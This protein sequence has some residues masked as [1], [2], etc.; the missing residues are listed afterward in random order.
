[1]AARILVV[2]DTQE[3]LDTFRELLE[4]EA[5]EVILYSYAIMD[6]REIE[7]VNPDLI[8]LDYIFGGEQSGW[9]MLQ[10]L[11]MRRSTETIPVIICTAATAQ[12]REIEGY[13]QAQGIKLVPKPFNIDTLLEAVSQALHTSPADAMI[14][15]RQD[16]PNQR[17]PDVQDEH[18]E[19]DKQGK[20]K[21]I[22][23]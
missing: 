13:L 4:E 9:Q 14:F 2:N 19:Q 5:Y 22:H 15:T 17:K 18:D 3:I 23:P 11:K 6:M 7:R 20:Q 8:I 16:A 10:K 1:M 12:V 21:N